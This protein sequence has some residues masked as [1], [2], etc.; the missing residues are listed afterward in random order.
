MASVLGCDSSDLFFT[1]GATESN[2]QVILSC[3]SAAESRRGVI[4][5]SVEHKSILAPA[6]K[7]SG[8]GFV[9]HKLPVDSGGSVLLQTLKSLINENI[10]LVSV[11]AANN[12][13]GTLQP[14]REVTECAHSHGALVHCDATQLLG[15]KNLDL[16][17]LGIDYASF[18][19]HKVY[20]PK[21][22]GAL[23]VR[24]GTPRRNLFP[25]LLGGGQEASLRAGTLN[26]PGIVGFAAACN[27]AQLQLSTEV[28]KVAQLRDL[29]EM[30]ILARITDASVNGDVTNRLP[31]TTSI[32]IP[33]VQADTLIANVPNICISGGSACSEGTVSPSHVLLAMGLSRQEAECTI[34]IGIGRYNRETE[35]DSACVGLTAAVD[36]LRNASRLMCESGQGKTQ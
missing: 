1:S 29:L 33:G 27:L 10:Y 22:V 15:R 36:Q 25:L 7:L 6:E 3:A 30:S 17:D 23:F 18:S 24:P 9:I 35:I 16:Y 31:G 32:T 34:R 21:G 13:V 26:V 8:L 5:S 28:S 11:Q 4:V 2:N 19:A 14:I 20:G 12:E